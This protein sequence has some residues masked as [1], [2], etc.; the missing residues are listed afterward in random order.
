[1]QEHR[2]DLE[3]IMRDRGLGDLIDELFAAVA[4]GNGVEERNLARGEELA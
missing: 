4:S 1:M 3:A 2:S